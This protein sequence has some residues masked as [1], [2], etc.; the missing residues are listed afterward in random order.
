VVER[1]AGARART[2]QR[3]V[4]RALDALA[5]GGKVQ[6]IGGGRARRWTHAAAAR[7]HDDLVTP[8][9]LPVD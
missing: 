5:G 3:T 9:P 7:I 2:S 1:R 6:S 4:Q 8:P